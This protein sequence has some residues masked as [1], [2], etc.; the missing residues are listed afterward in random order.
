[1]TDSRGTA[2]RSHPPI[3]RRS[4]RRWAIAGGV[5]AAWLVLK[6]VAGSYLS[7]TVLLVVF[8]VLG[9]IVVV[10]LRSMGITRD[11]PRIRQL[12]SRPWRDGQEVLRVASRHISDVFVITPSGSLLAPNSVELQMNPDDLVSLCEHM[13]LGVISMS[14]TEV[15]SEAIARSGARLSVPE[16]ADVYV[17]AEESVPRGR[18]RLRQGHPA[19]A[20]AAVQYPVPDEPVAQYPDAQYLEAPYLESPQYASQYAS[21]PASE[22][23]ESGSG[24][25]WMW[26][27][28]APNATMTDNPML[29]VKEPAYVPVP[30]LRLVTGDSVAQTRSSGARA[31]RGCVEL[32]LP[33]VP[34]VSREHARF[35]FADGRWWVTNLGLNGLMLNGDLVKGER[36][37]SD[38]DVIRWGSR[39]DSPQSRVEIG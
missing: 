21:E 33:D 30:L 3:P 8:A 37:L 24:E 20:A 28:S 31:G 32:T 6:V 15:Y 5:L 19:R 38:G 26:R 12:A 13:D 17:I 29:T 36:P 14:M 16:R 22:S 34:T 23:A 25:D 11:H 35:T 4:R 1:M 7:A 18:Y 2:R 27:E 39:P 10:F 9:G